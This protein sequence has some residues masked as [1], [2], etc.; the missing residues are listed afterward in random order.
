MQKFERF[1][2]DSTIEFL[3]LTYYTVLYISI[4][5]RFVCFHNLIAIIPIKII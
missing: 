3:A 1:S 4:A 5:M 2:K